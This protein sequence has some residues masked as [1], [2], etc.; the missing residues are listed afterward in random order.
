MSEEMKLAS[1]RPGVCIELDNLITGEGRYLVQVVGDGRQFVDYADEAGTPPPLPIFEAA[2]PV[3]VGDFTSIKFEVMENR[4]EDFQAFS[5]F[6]N[7]LLDQMGSRYNF[8]VFHR[9]VKW[10]YDNRKYSAAAALEAAQ[11]EDL[12]IRA[13]RVQLQNKT[14]ALVAELDD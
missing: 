8:L 7:A 5:D 4:P 6:I 1:F 9:A 2:R 3:L 14:A 13:A 10:G 12:A 11:A